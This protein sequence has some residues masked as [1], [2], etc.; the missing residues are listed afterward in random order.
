M[1]PA[2]LP[3]MARPFHMGDSSHLGQR[4]ARVRIILV[5]GAQT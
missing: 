2:A 5:G 4:R 3:G 1:G